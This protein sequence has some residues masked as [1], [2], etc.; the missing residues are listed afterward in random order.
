MQKAINA[1]MSNKDVSK[2]LKLTADL[3]DLHDENSFKVRA[4]QS[5]A[6][7][8]ER[9]EESIFEKLE[10]ELQEL[11]GIGKSLAK[12]LFQ[13]FQTGSFTPYETLLSKT[14]I[15][16]VEMLELKGLGPKKV[17]SLWQELN[18]NSI[19]ELLDA[20]KTHKIANV[21]G[22]GPKTEE[23][24]LNA[25]ESRAAFTGWLHYADAEK[26]AALWIGEFQNSGMFDK[27]EISGALRRKVE[28][29]ERLHF[30]VIP[31]QTYS[32]RSFA[33]KFSFAYDLKQ[34]GPKNHR[35]TLP[36]AYKIELQLSSPKRWGSDSCLN[37]A[38]ESHLYRQL[39]NTSIRVRALTR[40]FATENE[41]YESL[42]LP[43]F[44]PECR[45]GFQEFIKHEN[46]GLSRVLQYQDLKGILHNHSTYSDGADS[47][48]AMAKTCKS[49]GMQ[50]FGIA[51]HS[52][53]AFYARGL[54]EF[55]VK[56]QWDEIDQL[57]ASIKDF[58]IF[59]GIE[60]DILPDGRLDYEEE[61]LKGFDYVVASVHSNLR[62]D[63]Q[64]AT[65]RLIKAIE[66]PFTTILGHMT[67]RLLLRRE[68]YPLHFEKIFDACVANGVVLEL[69]ADPWR[70]DVDWR[71]LDQ[72]ERKGLMI[73][74]NP[75]AHETA[76]LHNMV[77]GYYCAKKACFPRELVFNAK[78]LEEV[79]AHFRTRHG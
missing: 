16:V 42:G 32:A 62:M 20:C 63:E 29:I 78:T 79:A 49:M 40:D 6:Y 44:D 71:L 69:N 74:I 48:L 55:R 57:N 8:I 15:G 1:G 52:K 28:V 65:A 76:G 56:Q 50:Y 18:I 21:K 75:D 53:S 12:E 35:F 47:V 77:Y 46:S 72:V 25:I 45:E 23:A 68:G 7:N 41:V 5:A 17:K 70:L 38:S 36:H 33:E 67:G 24:I 43:C 9:M 51:D 60:S 73:S 4:Y 39:N 61:L 59:K 3:M 66:N 37:T 34:S 27:I 58:H 30:Q 10:P 11:N 31:S 19:D 26:M 64:K 14:P 2:Y 54:E 22:F 13:W